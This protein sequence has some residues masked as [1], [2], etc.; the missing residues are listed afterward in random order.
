MRRTKAAILLCGSSKNLS[1]QK[2][3]GALWPKRVTIGDFE[4]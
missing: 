3:E 1:A 2:V 4:I